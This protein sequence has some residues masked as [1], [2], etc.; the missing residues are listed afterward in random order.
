MHSEEA[1][2][3]ALCQCR[4]ESPAPVEIVG[5]Q[6]FGRKNGG[7]RLC[8]Q[9]ENNR[10]GD[11]AQ[12]PARRDPVQLTL[13]PSTIG[14]GC[15]DAGIGTA[16]DAAEQRV[17]EP[18]EH[19]FHQAAQ[20]GEVFGSTEQDTAGIQKILRVGSIAPDET[21]DRRRRGSGLPRRSFACPGAAVP[22]NEQRRLGHPFV[23]RAALSI[24]KRAGLPR[25]AL[26]Q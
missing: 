24:V 12:P 23:V 19:L 2:L 1:E 8:V 9:I 5:A 3:G 22:E 20:S 18:V 7:R 25:A 10:I 6:G 13:G 16:L 14:S 11:P 21:S 17:I 4:P 15:D 26:A